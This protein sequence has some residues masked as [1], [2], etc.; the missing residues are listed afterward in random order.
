MNGEC[1][2]CGRSTRRKLNPLRPCCRKCEKTAPVA[3]TCPGA[4]TKGAAGKVAQAAQDQVRR[5]IEKAAGAQ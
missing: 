3:F 1:I 5:M 2:L 4:F